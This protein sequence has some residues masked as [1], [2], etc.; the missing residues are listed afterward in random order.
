MSSKEKKNSPNPITGVWPAGASGDLTWWAPRGLYYSCGG[1]WDDKSGAFQ[2]ADDSEVFK[3]CLDLCTPAS[4]YCQKQCNKKLQNIYD[5]NVHVDLP[6]TQAHRRCL[7]TCDIFTDLCRSQCRISAPGFNIDNYYFNC[8]DDAGC[9]RGLNQVPDQKCVKE[10]KDALLYCCR[11]NCVSS[12]NVDCQKE[13]E[14]LQKVILDPA[15]LGLP[16]ISSRN[17]AQEI[18]ES[19]LTGGPEAK[20]LSSYKLTTDSTGLYIFIAS[21]LAVFILIGAYLWY[22]SKKRKS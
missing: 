19:K 3:C 10:H 8:A 18:E 5:S 20:I 14:T 9:Q 21:L 7:N 11:K 6:P 22:N 15:A 17:I 16:Y 1:V 4:E 13:C 2:N 12:H